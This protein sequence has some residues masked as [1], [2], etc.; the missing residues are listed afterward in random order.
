VEITSTDC[1]LSVQVSKQVSDRENCCN[2][3]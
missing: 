3:G 2:D 1:R